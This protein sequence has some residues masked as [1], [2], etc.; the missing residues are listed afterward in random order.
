MALL[1]LSVHDRR[2]LEKAVSALEKIARELEKANEPGACTISVRGIKEVDIDPDLI[3]D[4]YVSTDKLLDD[5]DMK[6]TSGTF[7]TKNGV[8]L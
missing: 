3:T 4:G 1:E 2:L 8:W 5:G 7:D 6:I